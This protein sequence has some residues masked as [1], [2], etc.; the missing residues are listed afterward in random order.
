MQNDRSYR[1]KF[2]T[3]YKTLYDQNGGI[4]SL[5]YLVEILDSAMENFPHLWV[6]GEKYVFSDDV[7]E[8]G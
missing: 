6:N 5:C 3:A 2:S 4:N 1:N 8:A 7:I